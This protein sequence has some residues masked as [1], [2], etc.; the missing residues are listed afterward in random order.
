MA[1]LERLSAVFS[2]P[3]SRSA[4]ISILLAGGLALYAAVLALWRLYL[5]PLAK[6]KIPGPKLAALTQWYETYFD[7]FKNGGGQFLFQYLKL[8]E[9]YGIFHP[10][11]CAYL[12]LLLSMPYIKPALTTIRSNCPHQSLRGPYSRYRILRRIL[13][14]TL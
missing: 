8:H 13:Q 10:L 9:E 3:E 1:M 6:A 5:S 14:E 11:A 12:R 7:V 4:L 2:A